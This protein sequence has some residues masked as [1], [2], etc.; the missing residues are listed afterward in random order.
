[1]HTHQ[2]FSICQGDC[3]FYKSSYYLAYVNI[4]VR[5]MILTTFIIIGALS[6]IYY[7]IGIYNETYWKK[8]GIKFY[9]KNKVFGPMGEFVTSSRALFEIFNDVYKMYPDEPVVAVGNFLTPALY[10]KDVT[11]VNHVLNVDFNSFSHRGFDINEG[12]LLADNVVF[13]NGNRWKLMRQNMTPLFTS[14]KLKSMYYILDRSAL[15]FVEYLKMRPELLQK[16]TFKTVST[17]CCAAIGASVFGIENESVFDSPF[18]A[19]ANKAFAP[20]FRINFLVAVASMNQ[21]LFKLLRVKLFKDHE[22]FFIGAIRQVIRK[23][24]SENVKKH[25]FADLCVGLIN[26]GALKDH[27]TGLEIQATEEILAAQAFFF[28]VAGVEPSATALYG[29]LVE[30]GRNPEPLKRLHEEID[31]AFEKYDKMTYDTITEMEYLDMVFNEALRMYPP[32]G[33]LIR[34]CIKDT[35]LPSGNIKVESGTKIFTPL[36]EIHRDPKIYPDPDVFNPER[37]SRENAKNINS[38]AFIPFGEGKRLC[39]GVRYATLQVKSGLVHLLRHFT[40]KTHI[41]KGGIKYQKQNI[42]VRPTNI[43]VQIIPRDSRKNK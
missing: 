9:S 35:V 32:I 26:K 13:M 36:Y 30:L 40:V 6:V 31:N 25:D 16:D 20:T 11:N 5:K 4:N 42:Q 41:G 29:L 27:D 21:K 38:N 37:F 2:L 33:N 28:F 17:F 10:V 34:Q 7:L 1:M 23:R 15:D 8:R 24:Q 14:T 22:E 39:I 43:D 18:L 12:D 3:I 19:M